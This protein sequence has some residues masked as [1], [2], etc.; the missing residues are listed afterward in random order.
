MKRW[1][2]VLATIAVFIV[3]DRLGAKVLE[4]VILLSPERYGQLYSGKLEGDI[5]CA[6][7]SRGV[8]MLDAETAK[9][10]SG[11][12][13]ANISSNGLSAQMVKAL[14]L[15][16]LDHHP[17]PKSIVIE[18]SCVLTPSGAGVVGSFKPF[19]SHSPRLLS[20]G[21]KYAMTTVRATQVTRLYLF[22]TEFLLRSLFYL[23][24]N[25]SDQFGLLSGK[26]PEELIEEVE[27]SKPFELQIVP[28]ELQAL[29]ELIEILRERGLEVRLV[30]APYLPQYAQKMVNLDDS[31]RRIGDS[32][33]LEVTDLTRALT[34]DDLF[35]DRVH[36]NAGGARIVTKMLLDGSA[37]K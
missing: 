26:I 28:D 1:W 23:V 14:I 7:N 27:K 13:I 10:V 20:L 19:W 11:N 18:A 12:R 5:L 30:Y 33:K 24:E 36:M 8:Y 3:G 32:A 25:K 4:Y 31:L 6:G 29:S 22:N 15:D 21:E 2:L 17:K 35:V 16:Y 9:K 37:L 34:K